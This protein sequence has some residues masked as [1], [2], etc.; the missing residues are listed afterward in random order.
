[1]VENGHEEAKRRR[2]LEE[3]PDMSKDTLEFVISLPVEQKIPKVNEKETV[4]FLLKER[5]IYIS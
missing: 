4:F 1:V 3:Y 2:I 5:S